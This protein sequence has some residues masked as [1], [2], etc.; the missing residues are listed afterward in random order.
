MGIFAEKDMDVNVDIII[1]RLHALEK[2][3][4]RLKSLLEEHGIPYEIEKQDDIAVASKPHECRLSQSQLSLQ[5][6]VEL[7]Q[8]LFKGREDVFARRWYSNSTKQSGYQPVCK[9]EWIRD[10]CD[11]RKYRC[12]ECPNRLFASLSYEH[13]YNHLA[14]KDGLGRDVIGMYP[15]LKD[16]T[17]YFLCTDFDGKSCEHGYRNDVLAFVGV[18][19]EWNVP[20]SI[21]R[22]RSGNGAHVWIFIDAPITAIKARKLGKSILKEAMNKDARL[23]FNTYDRFF[24]NQDTLP[25][26]GLG[27]LVALPL[28]GM[29]RRSGNSVFV[30]E[31]F[32]I[33]PDQWLYLRGIQK[34]SEAA[35]DAIIQKMIHH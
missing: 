23:S 26:G 18:C 5:E 33:Y 21:E 10:Y 17:C 2:E 9:R 27:N 28:Q 25:E 15:V 22:S 7:F 3:N 31:N 24:P 20:C 35:I 16:N 29:A 12:V 8:S 1:A 6:K 19:K 32:Q 11:K 4:A 13:I 34:M 30:D 14:G